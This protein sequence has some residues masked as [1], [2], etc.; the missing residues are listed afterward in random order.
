MSEQYDEEVKITI[1][2]YRATKKKELETLNPDHKIEIQYPI[3]SLGIKVDIVDIAPNGTCVVYKI[4]KTKN[5]ASENDVSMLIAYWDGMVAEGIQPT[6]G[7]LI[8][9]DYAPGVVQIIKGYN[10]MLQSSKE[11]NAD[12]PR[13]N[14]QIVVDPNL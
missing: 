11:V 8:C 1:S 13:Y 10:E 2:T 7:Y 14:F 4:I 6:A 5:E 9:K 12:T 3:A